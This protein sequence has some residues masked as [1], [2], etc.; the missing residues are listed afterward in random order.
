[1]KKNGGAHAPAR[2]KIGVFLTETLAIACVHASA[3][4][5]YE[6][7]KLREDQDGGLRP[8]GR[9]WYV[10]GARP[11]GRVIT[12]ADTHDHIRQMAQFV[13]A[14]PDAP[15]EA[16]WR[17]VRDLVPGLVR[18]AWRC[19]TLAERLAYTTFTAMIPP[20]VEEANTIT[21]ARD[22]ALR[23][24]M[25]QPPVPDHGMGRRVGR[26]MGRAGKRLVLARATVAEIKP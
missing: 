13:V 12:V 14:H 5:T 23:E 10:D 1:M 18:P 16:V 3:G 4:S 25:P 22:E 24:A 9:L 11:A 19:C 8:D 17:F 6:T 15:P 20:M 26:Q 7:V 21:R 2:P